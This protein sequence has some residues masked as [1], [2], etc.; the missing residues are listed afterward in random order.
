MSRF[1]ARV[2][3]IAHEQRPSGSVPSPAPASKACQRPWTLAL[4]LGD[5]ER[6]LHACLRAPRSSIL[7]DEAPP[8]GSGAAKAPAAPAADPSRQHAELLDALAQHLNS[9]C[10]ER[11]KERAGLCSAEAHHVL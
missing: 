4:Q 6:A 3:A 11:C 1:C 8:G 5:C 2:A 10:E 9:A 7:A